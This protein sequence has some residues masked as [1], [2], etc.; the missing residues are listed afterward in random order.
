MKKQSTLAAFLQK[1]SPSKQITPDS[2]EE[3]MQTDRGNRSNKK[4]I[5]NKKEMESDEDLPFSESEEEKPKKASKPKA[6]SKPKKTAPE[7]RRR[8]ESEEEEEVVK[9]KEVPDQNRNT[10]RFAKYASESKSEFIP[11]KKKSRIIKRLRLSILFQL[12]KKKE[13]LNILLLNSSLSP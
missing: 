9:Q 5:S 1:K 10:N 2:E 4:R 8:D 12:L 7:K 6:K 13:R 3:E 11:A